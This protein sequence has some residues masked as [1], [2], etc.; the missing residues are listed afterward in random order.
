MKVNKILNASIYRRILVS[1]ALV[2]LLI[3][4]A[5]IANYPQLFRFRNLSAAA[6][7]S[8]TQMAFLQDFAITSSQFDANLEEFLVLGGVESEDHL[9][10]DMVEMKAIMESIAINAPAEFAMSVT[11]FEGA[12]NALEVDLLAL[13]EMKAGGSTTRELNEQMVSVFARL[14]TANDLHQGLS[15]ET[16]QQVQTIIPGSKSKS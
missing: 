4:V 7:P 14:E 5:S 13:K 1:F 16:L 10:Q 9:T 15:A 2:I 12:I 11:E 8:S 3:F 6:I